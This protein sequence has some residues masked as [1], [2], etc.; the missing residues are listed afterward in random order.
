MGNTDFMMHSDKSYISKLKKNKTRLI[1]IESQ[2]KKVVVV[3]VVV[4]VMVCCVCGRG[5]M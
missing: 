2:P 5:V 3:V 4:V 1:S